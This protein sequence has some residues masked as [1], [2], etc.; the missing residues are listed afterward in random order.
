MRI[1]CALALVLVHSLAQAQ[2]AWPAKPVRIIV[3]S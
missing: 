1:L 2:E 3:P